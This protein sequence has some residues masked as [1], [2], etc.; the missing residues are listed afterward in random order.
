MSLSP[1][2]IRFINEYLIDRNGTQAAIRAGYSRKTARQIATENLSKPHIRAVI[3]QKCRETEERLQVQRDDV[4]RGLLSAFMWARE[5]G[6]PMAMIAAMREVG[7]LLGYYDKPVE[8]PVLSSD[9][10][11]L[12]RQYE[13]MTDEELLALVQGE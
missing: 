8:K 12:K 5:Q 6:Q 13:A 4:L 7:K 3:D 10:K 1:R 9:L 11:E 2:Q